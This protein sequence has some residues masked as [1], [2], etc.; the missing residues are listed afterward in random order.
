MA[1]TRALFLLTLCGSSIAQHDHGMAAGHD[2]ANHTGHGAAGGHSSAHSSYVYDPTS[3]EDPFD[4]LSVALSGWLKNPREHGIEHRDDGWEE[5]FCNCMENGYI[6]SWYQYASA[7]YILDMCS[8]Q[9]G[10]V[11]RTGHLQDRHIQP[12]QSEMSCDMLKLIS[13]CFS[14]HCPECIPQWK[15]HC[16]ATH[17]TVEACNVDCSGAVA[18]FGFVSA[19]L[20]LLFIGGLLGFSGAQ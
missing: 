17:Y 7:L 16:D 9:G 15:H 13:Y 3:R 20:P 10:L 4:T 14:H 5:K 1:P 8:P 19:W 6:A 18:R 11:L 2:A 12:L